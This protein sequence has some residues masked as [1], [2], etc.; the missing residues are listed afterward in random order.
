M[1]CGLRV[2]SSCVKFQK[3]KLYQVERFYF[4]ALYSSD[5]EIFPELELAVKTKA[6]RALPT[7][8]VHTYK[9]TKEMNDIYA[10]LIDRVFDEYGRCIGPILTL[11]NYLAAKLMLLY[12]MLATEN[13]ATLDIL[14]K[15]AILCEKARYFG[16]ASPLVAYALAA[17]KQ[18]VDPRL[19]SGRYPWEIALKHRAHFFHLHQ[20]AVKL[21]QRCNSKSCLEKEK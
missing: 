12:P 3:N 10:M 6:F 14:R 17:S 19:I 2:C 13:K 4:H 7:C 9:N 20:L 18:A 21:F 5:L 8:D 11:T 15:A 16:G 1:V